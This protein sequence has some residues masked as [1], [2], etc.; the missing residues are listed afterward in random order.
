MSKKKEKTKNNILT[1]LRKVKN[2]TIGELNEKCRIGASLISRFE[3][4]KL[5]PSREAVIKIS[6]ALEVKPDLLLYMYGYIPEHEVNIFRKNPYYF[7][8][9]IKKMCKNEE[10]R[11]LEENTNIDDLN[12]ARTYDYIIKSMEEKKKDDTSNT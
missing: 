12:I 3:N 4:Y 10:S 6:N 1:I 2:L 5:I 7:M 11:L 8:D 9:K